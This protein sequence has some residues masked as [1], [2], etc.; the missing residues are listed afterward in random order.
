MK[1]VTQGAKP[2]IE[3]QPAGV[4]EAGVQ[5]LLQRGQCPTSLLLTMFVDLA[6]LASDD[7]LTD[8]PW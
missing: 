5:S 2:W 4:D 8:E 3:M 1:R 6:Q 7:H